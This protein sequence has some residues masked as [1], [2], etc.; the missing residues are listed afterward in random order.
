MIDQPFLGGGQITL[1]NLAKHLDKET[2]DVTVCTGMSGPLVD[3]LMKD[4]ILHI[5]VSMGKRL[6]SKA[7]DEIAGILGN[8]AFDILHTHGGV[9]GLHGRRAARRAETPVV[10]HTLH[11]I[12]YLHY[13]NPFLKR[14]FLSLER[15]L[16]R[17]S[18]A[19]VFVSQADLE[20]GRSL[21]LAAPEKMRL[22][23]NGIDIDPDALSINRR[24]KRI[25]LGF[26]PAQIVIGTV[27]RLHRQKGIK[28]FLA[29]SHLVHALYPET[30]FLVAGGGP[31]ER[32]LR[33]EVLRSGSGGY[34]HL[35][36]ERDDAL[37]ILAALDIFVLPSLWE[38]LPCAL[39]EAAALGKP[40]VAAGIDGIKEV[41]KDGETGLLVPARDAERLARSIILLIQKGDLAARLGSRARETIPPGYSMSA[42][43]GQT[44]ALYMELLSAKR[45]A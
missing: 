15:S 25:E 34:F 10:V 44:Q 2:F 18:D 9:A 14:A 41:I 40:I 20:K 29:A 11:G 42:M 6:S 1:L 13:R 23:R 38:G 4:G 35:L 22:I 36:G 28:H 43:I 5:P 21:R 32:E 30:R 45:P 39:I 31:L 7:V 24:T 37:G 3:K 19:L 16:S 27:A 17:H 26:D 33:D 12:H 8:R